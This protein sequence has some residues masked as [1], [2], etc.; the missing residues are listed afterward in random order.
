MYSG[1]ENIEI[2]EH[3]KKFAEKL[4]VEH[5]FYTT[6]IYVTLLQQIKEYSTHLT[7]SLG[8]PRVISYNF[9]AQSR[10]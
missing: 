7:I 4:I 6:Y 2:S 9:L 3:L 8:T 1:V 10:S 5:Q